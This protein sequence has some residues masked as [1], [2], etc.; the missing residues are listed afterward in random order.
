MRPTIGQIRNADRAGAWKFNWPGADLPNPDASPEVD[1]TW[2]QP[3]DAKV[4]ALG[5]DPNTPRS[6]LDLQVGDAGNGWPSF[7]RVQVYHLLGEPTPARV[8]ARPYSEA[9]GL[10]TFKSSDQRPRYLHCSLF[11]TGFPTNALVATPP[12]D[13]DVIEGLAQ[14]IGAGGVFD[15]PAAYPGVPLIPTVKFRVLVQDESGGRMF[16]VDVMGA[17]TFNFYA[18]SVTVFVLLKEGGYQVDPVFPVESQEALGPGIVENAIVGARILPIFQNQTQNTDIRTVTLAHPGGLEGRNTP[19]PPGA[20]RVQI[21][22]HDNTTIAGGY[23]L[24]F[25]TASPFTVVDASIAGTGAI[26]LTKGLRTEILNIPNSNEIRVIGTGA[27][28]PASQWSFI[29]EVDS[30]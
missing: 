17:R 19:I 4:T 12:I 8:A 20:K 28:T 22:N 2:P 14:G 24:E 26:D 23:R 7:R 11:A 6:L 29:Y 13:A 10:A 1:R 3:R 27:L 21:I 5:F 9:I 15:T 25:A 18:F 16:D 30:A